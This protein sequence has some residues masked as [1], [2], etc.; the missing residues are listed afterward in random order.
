MTARPPG[1]AIVLGSGGVKCAA[2]LGLA[3]VLER[4]R[5]PID[6]IVGCSG[7]AIF[8]TALATKQSTDQTI[9]VLKRLWTREITSRP[10]RR[11][12]A[13]LLF[14]R[15]LGFDARFGLRHDGA[16]LDRLNDAF[17]DRRIED[18]PVPLHIAATDF[19]TGNQHVFSRGRIVDAVRASLAIPF[20]FAPWKIDGRL[21]A[22]GYLSDPLPV[23][24]AIREGAHVIVAMGFEAPYQEHIHTGARFAFQVSSILSNNLLKAQF[25]FHGLAH[26]AE[27]VSI[28]PE[29]RERIRLFD[30]GKAEAIIE[31][32]ERAAEAQLPY[33]RRL[34]ALGRGT[35]EQAA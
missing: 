5:I 34:L 35:N 31:D 2:A 8:A 23:G 10:N 20:V 13:S 30:I 26:H 27:V 1:V 3:R 19:A 21:Y 14:P 24:V 33:L 22:D 9:K 28:I 6:M 12:V 16:I 11:G 18:L 4:E 32:G 25:A 29:F 15:L 17:G 7:G